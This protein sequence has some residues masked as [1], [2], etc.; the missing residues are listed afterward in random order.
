[1]PRY[2]HPSFDPYGILGVESS[3]TA[4]EIRTAYRQMAMEFHPD[5]NRGDAKATERMQ[6][7]NAAWG[8]LRDADT[9]AR[10]DREVR[11]LAQQRREQQPSSRSTG[12]YASQNVGPVTTSRSDSLGQRFAELVTRPTG[13][14]LVAAFVA[15]AISTATF[16]IINRNVQPQPIVEPTLIA[17]ASVLTP[18]TPGTTTDP[19]AAQQALF[20]ALIDPDVKVATLSEFFAMGAQVNV[21]DSQ[22]R[23]P[24]D[25][26]TAAG[27]DLDVLRFLFSIEETTWFSPTI[28]HDA[29]MRGSAD[30]EVINLILANSDAINLI[31][32]ID[33]EGRTLLD[34]AL[35]VAADVEALRLILQSGA[36][37]PK[38]IL[39]V[40]LLYPSVN[41]D[42]VNALLE[43]GAG[44]DTLD[45]DGRTPYDLAI[46][47]ER[48]E[49]IV[50]TLTTPAPPQ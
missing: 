28:L 14:V 21:R 44:R 9:R 29:L 8:I 47:L 10:Y 15:I 45:A 1:M 5:S 27:V 42:H 25:I 12:G 43:A 49:D 50:A 48:S 22:G 35:F 2:R 36:T 18:I 31:D 20:A 6:L 11:E 24:I 30:A 16:L 19:S 41:V 33:D 32:A 39:H 4:D 3:A 37:V 13:Q 40:A 23:W 46:A 26:A 38:A 7:V 34:I 17:T